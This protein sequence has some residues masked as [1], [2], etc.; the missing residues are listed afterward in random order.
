MAAPVEIGDSHREIAVEKARYWSL[1][2]GGAA[3]ASD[4]GVSIPALGDTWDSLTTQRAAGA[5]V[6]DAERTRHLLA[7]MSGLTGEQRAA[8]RLEA[9]ALADRGET[10]GVWEG[11]G[12]EGLML[13][14]P[15]EPRVEGAW[16]G[17]LLYYPNVGMALTEMSAEGR[18]LVADPWGAIR[19][20]M[21]TEFRREGSAAGRWLTQTT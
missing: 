15:R 16:I 7:L 1:A 14:E 21:R 5:G 3:I 9:V 8:R 20:L 4:G 19:E 10:I 6:S 12:E 13:P 11:E 18:R 2:F 17:S